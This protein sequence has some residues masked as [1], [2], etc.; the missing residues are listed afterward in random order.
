MIRRVSYKNFI[1]ASERASA[2]GRGASRKSDTTLELR[3]RRTLWKHGLRYRK[4]VQEL[5]GKPDIVFK[6]AQ[7]VVFCDGNFWHG[8]NWN[9]RKIKLKKGSNPKYWVAK[10]ERNM[11]RDVE[12]NKALQENGWTVLRFWESEINKNIDKVVNIVVRTLYC[13]KRIIRKGSSLLMA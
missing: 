13:K 1:P 6:R 8:K 5:P 4:N 2:A 10:I 7:V 12:N 9:E 11:E 3:L